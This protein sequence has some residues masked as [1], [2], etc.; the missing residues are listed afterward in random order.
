M[1]GTDQKNFLERHR[2][3]KY[4]E[5]N[6]LGQLTGEASLYT[7]QKT[8]KYTNKTWQRDM[9]SRCIRSSVY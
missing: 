2:R 1:Q 9:N 6:R 7:A 8:L 3:L 5:T 4:F